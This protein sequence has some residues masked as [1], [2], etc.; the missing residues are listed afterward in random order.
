MWEDYIYEIRD[1]GYGSLVMKYR[2][3]TYDECL[4]YLT[5]NIEHKLKLENDKKVKNKTIFE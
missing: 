2:F 5:E 4:N 3:P 1:Y